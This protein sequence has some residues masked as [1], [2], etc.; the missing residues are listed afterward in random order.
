MTG[1][2][3]RPAQLAANPQMDDDV[4]H[5][6]G[7]HFA[8]PG[9]HSFSVDI[10]DFSLNRG[11]RLLLLGPSGSGK[12]TLLNLLAGIVLPDH[13]TIE[14]LGM[15]L[16]TL[17]GATRDRFRAEHF[18]IIFQMF[19]LLPYGSALDNVVLPLSFAPNRRARAHAIS[20]R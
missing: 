13:G 10:S 11:E 16:T 4:V 8:W 1:K 2:R 17:N 20:R 9:R 18:G 15:E 19:N 14:A 6:H 7:I 12:S 3:Q 5:M